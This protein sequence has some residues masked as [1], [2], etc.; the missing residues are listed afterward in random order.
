MMKK[1]LLLVSL[2]FSVSA[3]AEATDTK[4]SYQKDAKELT[5]SGTLCTYGKKSKQSL[6]T[7]VISHIHNHVKDQRQD[8][9]TQIRDIKSGMFGRRLDIAELAVMYQ[10]TEQ[11][12]EMDYF[13][14]GNSACVNFQAVLDLDYSRDTSAYFNFEQPAAWTFLAKR[15]DLVNINQAV[16]SIYPS[17]TLT[18][19]DLTKTSLIELSQVST[20]YALYKF[21]AKTYKAEQASKLNTVFIDAPTAYKN[22]MAAYLTSYQFSIAT[23]KNNANWRVTVEPVASTQGLLFAINYQSKSSANKQINND[24]SNLPPIATNNDQEL[25]NLI[26]LHLEMMEFIQLLKSR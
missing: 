20:S 26:V 24:P 8:F 3:H 5:T 14:E 10:L 2:I 23:D 7:A 25:Q 19:K 13:F 16:K 9:I 18:N 11:H 6:P 1:T 21:D 17:I 15:N 22:A 4:F 12:L